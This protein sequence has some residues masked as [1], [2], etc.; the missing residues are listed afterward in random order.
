MEE[1][2]AAEAALEEVTVVVSEEATEAASEEV[3]VVASEV[4]IVVAS[5]VAVEEIAVDSEEAA[6]VAMASREVAPVSAVAL[7][8][9]LNPTKDSKESSF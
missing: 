7:E 8:F 2:E 1:T 9:S 3:T 4:E 6:A 5:E